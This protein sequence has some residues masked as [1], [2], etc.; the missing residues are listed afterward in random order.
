MGVIRFSQITTIPS[1]WRT[2]L[3]S[4]HRTG[5]PKKIMFYNGRDHEPMGSIVG[6]FGRLLK[7]TPE[8]S[9]PESLSTSA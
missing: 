3:L 7:R 4:I 5:K 1:I 8:S 2:P 6:T 9:D